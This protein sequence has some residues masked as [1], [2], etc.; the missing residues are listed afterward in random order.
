MKK[1]LA[2]TSNNI[3]NHNRHWPRLETVHALAEKMLMLFSQGL[4]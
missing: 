4:G 2:L 1:R 3:S